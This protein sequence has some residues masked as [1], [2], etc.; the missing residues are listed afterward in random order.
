MILLRL[1]NT[2]LRSAIRRNLVSFPSEI[3]VFQK[4]TRCDIQWRIV[5]LY[6]V[7]GW[8]LDDIASRFQLCRERA[9]QI[10]NSWRIQ[11]IHSGYIQPIDPERFLLDPEWN[12][13]DPETTLGMEPMTIPLPAGRESQSV[14]SW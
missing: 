2:G 9:R 1:S 5:Q 4:L 8:R 7:R 14:S 10:L 3:P 13:P 11:A 6:F 12:R